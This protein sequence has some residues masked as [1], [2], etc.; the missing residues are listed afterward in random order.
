MRIQVAAIRKGGGLTAILYDNAE[1]EYHR[2]DIPSDPKEFAAELEDA[3][4]K[5]RRLV[6]GSGSVEIKPKD[7]AIGFTSELEE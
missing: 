6:A 5:T 3:A 7:S 2:F 1:A 4:D